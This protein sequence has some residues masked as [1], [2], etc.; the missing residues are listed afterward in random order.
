MI[1]I[2]NR[3]QMYRLYARN[4]FYVKIVYFLYFKACLEKNLCL[5]EGKVS[6]TVSGNHTIKLLTSRLKTIRDAVI[7]QKY[8]TT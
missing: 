5:L 8:F 1:S 3:K 2:L 4:R 7:F 6:I